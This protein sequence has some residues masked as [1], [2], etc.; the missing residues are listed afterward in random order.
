MKSLDAHPFRVRGGVEQSS[1]RR[2][3]ETRCCPLL[4]RESRVQGERRTLSEHRQPTKNVDEALPT[5]SSMDTP[6]CILA[7]PALSH[8][9]V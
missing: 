5:H 9:A 3:R 6:F 1:P 7:G 8:R 2:D 4:T